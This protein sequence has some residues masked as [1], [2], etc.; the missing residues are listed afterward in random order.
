MKL[1]GSFTKSQRRE[2]SQNKVKGRVK[3]PTSANYGRNGA[4]A[5]HLPPAPA[6]GISR[7]VFLVLLR[8]ADDG[9]DAD[10]DPSELQ[11]YESEFEGK[12]RHV[13]ENSAAKYVEQIVGERAGI[14]LAELMASVCDEDHERTGERKQLHWVVD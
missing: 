8:V 3:G 10:E 12:Q 7:L 11:D 13:A 1:L 9:P 4:P 2:Q 14:H 5:L 6:L